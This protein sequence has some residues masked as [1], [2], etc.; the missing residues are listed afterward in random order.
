MGC[1]RRRAALT[2]IKRNRIPYL[3]G[4]VFRLSI[5][6]VMSDKPE[7]P[8]DGAEPRGHMDRR[9]RADAQRNIDTLLQTAMEVFATSGVDAPVR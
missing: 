7:D 6:D 4:T 1:Q 8:D 5:E 2:S 9:V 3:Y